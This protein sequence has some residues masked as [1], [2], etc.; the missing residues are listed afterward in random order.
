MAA[1]GQSQ[2][3]NATEDKPHY[4]GHRQRLRDRL[5][6]GG[7]DPLPDYELLEFLLYSARPQGDT[8]PLAKELI[9]HFGGFAA[10]LSADRAALAD[11]GLKDATIAALLAVREA[12][13][14]MLR[15]EIIAKPIISNWQTLIDYC[16][17]QFGFAAA[18]EFHLL[19]LDRKNALIR[20]ERQQQGTV[21]HT[22]VYPREVVKRALELNATAI[23]MVHN[24]PSG[25]VT[26]SRADIEMT[27]QVREAA[28]AVGIALHDHLVIG[29]GKHASF[30][31]LGLI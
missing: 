10:V 17:T 2:S 29:R 21:D 26:P 9:K 16:N 20:D 1:R 4:L 22:P 12:A 3:S 8:K 28:K 18:E 30:R 5:L 19:F 24:H 6:D 14:G 7:T 31:S 23:I 15:G 25:D 27:K 11:F 13:G